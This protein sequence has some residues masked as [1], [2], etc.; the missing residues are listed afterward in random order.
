MNLH[1]N[2]DLLPEPLNLKVIF[3]LRTDPPFR[4]SRMVPFGRAVIRAEGAS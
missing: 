1:W 2:P 4:L 3:F